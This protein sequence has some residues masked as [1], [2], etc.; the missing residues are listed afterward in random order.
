MLPRSVGDMSRH[1][2][3]LKALRAAATALS[4]SST[5]AAY[6]EVISV[7]SLGNC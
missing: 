1:E 6:T 4:T 3:S 7:S 5:L 2:G